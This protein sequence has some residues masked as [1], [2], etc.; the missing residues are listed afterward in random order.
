VLG[1]RGASKHAPVNTVAAFRLALESGAD[2]IELDAN[3]T[4]DGDV[5]VMH[6]G[7]IGR[8]TNGC[9]RLA[10]LTLA[11]IQR[12]DAGSWFGP[13]FSKEK[14]PSLAQVFQA[15][16]GRPVYDLEI[17]NLDAPGN[18]LE[19]KVIALVRQFNLEKSVL[20]SSFNPLAVRIFR[21]ELPEAPAM[22]LLM[23]GAAG[24]TELNLI[25]R[26]ASPGMIGL[27]HRDL[28]ERLIHRIGSLN[29]L[30]WGPSNSQEVC[31]AVEY[32][33]VGIIV[34]DPGMARKA[35]EPA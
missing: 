15:L 9:G 14:A 10:D 29:V 17:K 1:H 33:A 2:G 8:T 32:G 25:G 27:F 26:W 7:Q 23:G 35:L 13:T 22:L 12:L 20:I 5:V 4:R 19:R 30:V 31:L 24:L 28:S 16:G 21:R 11:E 6:D 3:L 34:D 18:G